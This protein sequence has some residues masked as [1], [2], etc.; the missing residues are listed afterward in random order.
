MMLTRI[1]QV[2]RE[3]QEPVSLVDLAA[4]LEI[5]V[6]A[7]EGMLEQLVRQGKLRKS[8][9]MSVTECHMEHEAGL[10]GDLCAFLTHG[11]VA[12]R[13]EIVADPEDAAHV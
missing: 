6:S 13:Y 3:T 7:L 11:D 10:Y 4:Q 8:E 9:E 5:E 1:L 2:L 12:V